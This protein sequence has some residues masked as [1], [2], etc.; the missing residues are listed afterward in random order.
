MNARLATLP[1]APIRADP[2][3]RAFVYVLA[4]AGAEDLL[5]IGLTH[6]PLARWS[7]FHPRWFE[8]FDLEHSLL[9][10][11]ETRAD[12]QALETAMH[13][14]FIEHHSPPPMTM[15]LAAGGRTEWYR[16]AHA[17]V[18]R[19]LDALAAKGYVVHRGA[20][21]WLV[22]AMQER[23]DSLHGLLL[24]ALEEHHAGWLTPMQRQGVQDLVDAHAEFDPALRN[25]LAAAGL[26][27]PPA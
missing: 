2:Q 26:L 25:E 19:Y 3:G 8:A 20:R 7:A 9:V 15:R 10:E 23:R 5:K 18:S 1:D 21:S 13:R 14:H 17:G 6:D 11:T 12:A 24:Q 16:G 27:L 4:S 22:H